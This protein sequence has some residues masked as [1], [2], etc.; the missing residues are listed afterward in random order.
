M[1]V[2]SG[3]VASLVYHE[4]AWNAYVLDPDKKQ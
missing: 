4:E 1:Q 3:Q 2:K